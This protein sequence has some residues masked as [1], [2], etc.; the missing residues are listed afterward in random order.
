MNNILI[1]LHEK[2]GLFFF[3]TFDYDANELVMIQKNKHGN[4]TILLLQIAVLFFSLLLGKGSPCMLNWAHSFCLR[5]RTDWHSL[6]APG[7]DDDPALFCP[8]VCAF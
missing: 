3:L 7:E 6:A 8:R 2:M 5:G 1:S 4:R